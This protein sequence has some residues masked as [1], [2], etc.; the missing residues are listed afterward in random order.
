MNTAGPE[1][2]KEEWLRRT[3]DRDGAQP[4]ISVLDLAAW[5]EGRLSGSMPARI[6][7]AVA[8]QPELRHAVYELR[9]ILTEP[10]PPAPAQMVGR[11][12]ALVRPEAKHRAG[13]GFRST[14]LPGRTLR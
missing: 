12:Q 14:A 1:L 6:S 13:R 9:A 10:W 5:L 8:G 3:G 7:V 2:G 4:S 11:A